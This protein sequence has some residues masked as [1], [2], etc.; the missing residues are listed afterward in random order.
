MSTNFRPR[1][2]IPSAVN[3]PTCIN[4]STTKNITKEDAESILSEF[5]SASE[6]IATTIPGSTTDLTFDKTGF[7]NSTANG[8]ILGQLR[9]VQRD[10]RGLPPLIEEP[11]RDEPEPKNKK[12]K[13]DSEGEDNEDEPKRKKIKFDEEGEEEEKEE[14]Q[15][16][17]EL[18]DIEV[19]IETPKKKE[20]KEK[21][22]K[23]KKEKKEKV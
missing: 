6:A 21:K 14:E 16:K 3:T 20:K 12:I 7:S 8:A 2:A 9:R 18:S 10:L 1:R 17:A 11:K 5:I 19:D 15:E 13:F 4:V 22:D 23:K